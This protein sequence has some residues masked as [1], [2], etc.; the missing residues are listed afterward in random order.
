[1]SKN[2]GPP[3]WAQMLLTKF[4]HPDTV[5]EV[6]GDLQEFFARWEKQYGIRK[7]YWKYVLT[8]FTLL[9]P[10]AKRKYSLNQNIS[11]SS[12]HFM[13]GSYFIMSWRTLLKN[14]V[15]S[16]INIS[17]LTLGL[18]TSIII[19]LVAMNEFSYDNFH[20]NLSSIHLLM[21][22]QKTNDGISTGKSTA[23]PTAEALRTEFPEVKY[24]ARMA[25]FD[26][27]Q[28]VVNG[29]IS[30][31]SGIYA[32]PDLFRIMTFQPVAGDVVGSLE[33]NSAIVI[34][35][36]IARKLFAEENPI[37]KTI[38]FNK[39]HSL[40]VGAVVENAPS[41]SSVKFNMV[42]P[43]ALFEKENDWLKKWDDNRIMTWM[44]LQP[45][46]N[47][48]LFDSKVTELLQQRSNDKTVSLFAYP[49]KEL[50]LR[51]NFS[52]GHPN[53]GRILAVQMLIGFGVFMLLIACINF[54]NIATAQSEH[55]AKEV[56]VRKVLGASRKWIIFQFLTES[57]VITFLSLFVAIGLAFTILPWFNTLTHSGIS[58]NLK[59][60]TIWSLVLSIGL[61]T[62]I[63]AGSYPSFFLSRF[64][65][66]RVLK[67]RVATIK[68]GG[69]RRA[70]VTFQ[71]AISIFFLIS[72]IIM[73]SQFEFVR[74][75]PLGYEQENLID[76]HLDSTLSA[77]FAYLKTEVLKIPDVKIA[78]GGSDNILYSGGSITGM[79]WPGR[80]SGEDLSVAVA[81]VEYDWSKTIGIKILEGRDFDPA[82]ISDSLGCIINESA[83]AKMGLQDPIGSVVGGHPVIGVF[84]NFV[85]NN[86]FGTIDPMA[87]Y[88]NPKHLNHF[89]LRIQNNSEWRQTLD[90]IEKIAKGISPDFPFSFSFTKEEYQ[91]RFNEIADTS[92]MISIFGEMTIFIS[93]LGLFGLSG[94]VAEK[95]SKEMSIR[96]V[97]GASALRVIIALTQD[98]LRPV[99]YALVLVIP[100][101]ILIAQSVLSNISYRV[102]LSW[103]MFA[104]GGFL[105]FFIA[106]T[107]VLYH[108]WRTAQENPVVRLKNE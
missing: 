19:M 9:H 80:R 103:W 85:F 50:Y 3:R 53:G 33:S 48:S 42:V 34:T 14:R 4:A 76:I 1:M 16:L 47:I 100:L 36:D 25:G 13:I 8:V 78:T 88:L 2:I 38:L 41:N 75:R 7:A 96:K 43:F 12:I 58:F 44:K 60:L 11:I 79:D 95:R 51:G 59:S 32:D 39:H 73:N 29:K 98:F 83:V 68:G 17:G 64:M 57:F 81:N 31:E 26:Q 66:A 27:Q 55:R 46:T 5:E 30:Y 89:Y 65:P 69:F 24:A 94:F 40:T 108:G 15:S 97:F 93:C 67:G 82:F 6:E 35:K 20:S 28:V 21:K 84:Q 91:H 72:T 74:N 18:A 107:I 62:S 92:L 22:N 61:I 104:S 90:H 102:P 56:G 63:L 54:M 99:V 101:S 71:F 86:P 49:L 52:N 77:K 37:G 105:T 70:L 106:V 87:V 10:F 45:A 23:G